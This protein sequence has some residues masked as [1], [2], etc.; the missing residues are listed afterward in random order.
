MPSAFIPSEDK[1]FFVMS[2][3]LPDAASLQRT[4]QVV[5]RVEQILL[6]D[7]AI[8]KTVTLVGTKVNNLGQSIPGDGGA[9]YNLATLS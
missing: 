1:G 6:K 4:Q 3:N 7:P 5:G 9:I 8:A 2:V